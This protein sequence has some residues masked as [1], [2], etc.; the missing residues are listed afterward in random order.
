MDNSKNIAKTYDPKEFEDRLYKWWEEEGFFTPKIDKNKKPY[1]II[2]PPPNITGQLHLGHA[3]DNALQDFLIRAKRMQGYCTLWLPGQDHAS[4]ATEVKV[5]KELLKEDIKKKEIGRDAFLEKVWEWTDTYR[6]KIRGQ[7]KKMGVSADFTRESFTMDENLSKAVR[8]VFVRLYNEGLIYQG[9]RI[10]NWCPNCQTALSDAEIEYVEQNGHF[11]HIKYPVVNSEEFLEIATTRPETLLGDTAVAVNPKDQRYAHLVG[12]TL[13]L[14]LVNREIPIVADEYVDMEFGTGAVK[15]TPAHD[16]NDYQVGKR[17]NLPEIIILNNDGTIA[18]GYGKY[19]GLDR[20][21]ARKEI[22]KDLKEQEFLVKIKEH[23]HNVST[24]D[25]C[26]NTIEPMISKQWYVKMESLAKPA[27]EAVKNGDTKFVPERFDKTYFNW[28]ENIQDWC[29]SRQLWWGHR[30][31][32]WYC[33]DCGEVIVASKDPDKCT[34]CGSSNLKQDE[35]VLDTWFSSALWPFS[36]LGWPDKTED[37]EYFYPTNTLVTGYDIIFFWVARMVFS[38]IHNMGETPFEHVLIHGLVRDAEGR[39][40]SKSLGNGVDPLEVIDSFG[41]DALRF[42]LI[43]GNAP[44]NDLRYKTE[45]VEAARNF[46]NK[47]WNASRFVLMNLDKD[48]MKKYQDCEEYTLGDKWILSRAN[49]VAKEI[50]ENIEKFELGIASQK[51]YDFMWTE[52]CDWYIEIV[53]PV[54]YGEDEK[55]KGVAFNVLNRVLTIGLQLLHPI[56]P[57]ITEEIY[58]HLDGKYK[59]ISISKWPE[60][61]EKAYDV[62]AEEDMS[63]I[64]EAIKSLRNVRAEMNVPPSRKAKLIILA[65]DESKDAFEAGRVYFEKLASASSIEFI[66]S[67]DKVDSNAV[68]VITKGGEIFM[69]LLDLIDLDKELERLNK[70]NN[71]LKKEIERV[72]KKLSNKGFVSKAPSAVIEEERDKGEK[73][74]EMLEAVVERINNLK[75][76]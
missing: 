47:I 73:Y 10:T 69:P 57:Y 65:N 38:G 13:M 26:G 35:D 2:M 19:S 58:Q 25:R 9:N 27:I 42:T 68:S 8:E 39:K 29:I 50:T 11:W 22:V 23:T 33:E 32:V 28:M 75:N 45:K 34:K 14:P 20:Y 21:E 6:S 36:T 3:L 30:I 24:H 18:K 31:P 44:G 48:V 64:I 51:V 15:I 67:K 52:F 40:M 43:T 46:A 70:E 76:N 55:A 37:L 63:Y 41:A 72:D 54:M 59:S 61:S 74:R 1:T 56:M 17:H 62:K 16:P 7:L 12:K 49:T 66:S 5:E 4:I 60:Y 53:K 71:R